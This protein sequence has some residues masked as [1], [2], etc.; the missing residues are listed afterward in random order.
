MS[1]T[2]ETPT[3]VV[4]RGGFTANWA[5]VTKLLDLEARGAAFVLKPDG[6]FRVVPATVLTAD[7]VAFLRA[8]RDEA[9]RILDYDADRYER[10]Q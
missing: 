7:D 4:F 3:L 10:T 9:R 8:N 2:S 1:A 5:V 6:G